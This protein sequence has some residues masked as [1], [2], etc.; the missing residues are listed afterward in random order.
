VFAVLKNMNISPCDLKLLGVVTCVCMQTVSWYSYVDDMLSIYNISFKMKH[1]LC[2]ASGA[3][4]P[5]PRNNPW[6]EPGVSFLFVSKYCDYLYRS[7]NVYD[8]YK[9]KL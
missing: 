9:R 3:A 7:R 2:V 6:S 4:L 8:T 1:K 5:P